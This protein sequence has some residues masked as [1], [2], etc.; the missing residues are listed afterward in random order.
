MNDRFRFRAWDITENK[1]YDFDELNRLDRDGVVCIMDLLMEK[2]LSIALMQSTGLR[3]KNG[4]LIYEGDVIRGNLFDRHLPTK[5]EVVYDTENTCFANKNL[6][7][8]TFL[9]KINKIEVIGN[10]YDN[11][12]PIGGE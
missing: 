6:A 1:M 2:D 9:F 10:I 4:V 7:G 11:P 3:D 12:D 5:G 8:L